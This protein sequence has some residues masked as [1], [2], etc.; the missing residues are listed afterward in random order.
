MHILQSGLMV[1]EII[2]RHAD[3][4]S[5]A[6]IHKANGIG[7]YWPTHGHRSSGSRLIR[8]LWDRDY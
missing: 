1:F 6:E 4:Q 7:N 2:N 3:R 8:G 5:L